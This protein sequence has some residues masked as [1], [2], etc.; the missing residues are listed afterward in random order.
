MGQFSLTCLSIDIL[1]N[2]FLAIAVDNLADA[3]ALGESDAE[4]AQEEH[5]DYEVNPFVCSVITFLSA[6]ITTYIIIYYCPLT[7]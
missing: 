2:V 7:P 3:D 5:A 4:K 1:L 6:I